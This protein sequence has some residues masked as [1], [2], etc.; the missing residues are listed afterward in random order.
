MHQLLNY[1]VESPLWISIFTFVSEDAAYIYGLSIHQSQRISA[2]AFVFYFC[3]GVFLGDMGLYL[4]GYIL[5]K[6]RRVRFIARMRDRLLA[7]KIQTQLVDQSASLPPNWAKKK[8]IGSFEQFLLFTRCLPGSRTLTYIYCGFSGYSLRKFILLLGSSSLIYAT[9]G[10]VISAFI[11]NFMEALHWSFF[12]LIA[13]I[14]FLVTFTSLRLSFS[15][16]NHWQRFR[17]LWPFFCIKLIRL[18]RFEFWPARLMYLGIVPF[19]VYLL[20]RY[21]GFSSALASNPAISMS[22]FIGE[23]KSDIDL[24]LQKWLPEHRLVTLPLPAYTLETKIESSQTFLQQLLQQNQLGLPVMIKPEAGLKGSQVQFCSQIKQLVGAWQSIHGPVILQEVC[25][26]PMEWG[27]FYYRFPGQSKGHIFSVTHKVFPEIIGDGRTSLQDLVMQHPEYRFRYP[28]LLADTYKDNQMV[29]AK[30]EKKRLVFHGNHAKGC[31]FQ[32]GVRYVTP[33]IENMLTKRFDKLEGFYIGRIDLCFTS[34]EH[35]ARGEFK[36]IEINGAGAES[37]NIYDPAMPVL[38]AY[39]T[40][41][42]QWQLVF[43]IGHKNK[44]AGF[45]SETLW[46]FFVALWKFR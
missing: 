42:K 25:T 3:L 32:D 24:L 34:L 38:Q 5:T 29:L 13:F 6:F 27:V 8:F 21:R 20:V 18:K 22:G 41:C 31:L 43:A 1:I 4:T 40:L 45:V 33:E 7:K 10:V 36:I 35:L 26:E 23:K 28:F 44:A 30:G 2:L 39:K 14:T 9:L 16:I 12:I 17:S 11:G 19:F 37:T 46:R 15:L